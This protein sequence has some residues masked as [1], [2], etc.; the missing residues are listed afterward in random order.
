[1]AKPIAL[2][3]APIHPAG[4]ELL[5]SVFDVVEVDHYAISQRELDDAL[6]DAD[7]VIVRSA[8]ITAD[9]LAG[10]DRLKIISKH[11]V[12]LDSIDVDAAT[13]RGILITNTAGSNASSVAE[14][15]VALMLG[16]LHDIPAVDRNVRRAA[17]SQPGTVVPGDLSGANVA[18]VGLGNIGRRVANIC[19][20]G[21]GATVAA[22]DP[23]VPLETMRALGVEKVDSLDALLGESDIV[24]LHLPL[25][26]ETRGLIGRDELR[27]MTADAVLVNAARGGSVDEAALLEVLRAG[28]LR[29]AGID[30]LDYEPPRAS[31]PLFASE[32]IIFSPHIG[33]GSV[34]VRRRTAVAAAQ[35][36]IDVF[37]GRR[38]PNII[39]PQVLEHGRVQLAA[40]G[41][42]TS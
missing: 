15:A 3:P 37:A 1:M 16:V 9:G 18:I 30:V 26:V 13:E 10:S 42:L 4:L 12:G 33:A 7:A 31:E 8:P 25:T 27:R 28:H 17:Y 32:R 11:G 34:Q 21:F 20:A 5:A 23:Y 24:T 22:Y 2:V 6:A 39:N 41:S 35:A 40:D 19:A 36:A 14:H 29:G 38:P